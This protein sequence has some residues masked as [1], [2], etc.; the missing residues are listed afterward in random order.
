M[1]QRNVKEMLLS[2][3]ETSKKCASNTEEMAK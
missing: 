1:R 3:E 2:D